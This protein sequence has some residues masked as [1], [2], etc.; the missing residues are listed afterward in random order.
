[1]SKKF[2]FATGL[3]FW[4]GALIIV[5]AGVEMIRVKAMFSFPEV[6]LLGFVIMFFALF[7]VLFEETKKE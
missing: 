6:F 1:M 4:I 3:V 5:Y 7:G 2:D